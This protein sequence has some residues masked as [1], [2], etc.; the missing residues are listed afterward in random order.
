MR[1]PNTVPWSRRY[2]KPP[3]RGMRQPRARSTNRVG[4]ALTA[5]AGVPTTSLGLQ[6]AGTA[7][8]SQPAG[9]Y[10]YNYVYDPGAPHA[11]AAYP[12]SAETIRNSEEA[13]VAGGYGDPGGPTPEDFEST[14]EQY[15][16][17]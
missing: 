3:N 6:A 16:T 10:Q 12:G 14:M 13:L 7:Q 2:R 11:A 8:V 1:K 4:P 17:L 5:Q 9:A 15:R